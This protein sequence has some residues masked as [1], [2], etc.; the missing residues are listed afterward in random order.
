MTNV[1]LHSD[2]VSLE[3]EEGRI[4]ATFSRRLIEIAALSRSGIK[5]ANATDTLNVLR[6]P[7][8][9]MDAGGFVV[10]SNGALDGILDSEIRVKDRR[11]FIRDIDARNSLQSFLDRLKSMPVNGP[12]PAIE[13]IVVP[14]R[15]KLPIIL[16]IW[17][18]AQPARWPSPDVRA[19]L[20]L[21]ALGPKPGPP[22]AILARAFRLTPSEAK[23]ASIIARGAAPE[24]A[25]RELNIS[26]E[27]V[28]NQLKS[29][30]AKTGT[31]RQGELVALLLQVD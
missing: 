25:A 12:L 21:N 15:D 31:H 29:I 26:R 28:R 20:T 16:R 22:A 18:I 6:Q 17:P 13:P 10:Q 9:L 4:L 19:L 2:E 23:L 24:T 14:R 11:L 8:L 27:T 1:V 3:A 7:A 30:F 5:D